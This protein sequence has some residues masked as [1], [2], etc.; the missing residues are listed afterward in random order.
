[1]KEHDIKVTE[2]CFDII[3]DLII[4]LNDAILVDS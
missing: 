1:M 4:A 2:E 3:L